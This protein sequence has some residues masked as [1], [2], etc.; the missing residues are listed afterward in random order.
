M[1]TSLDTTRPLDVL[2][3]KPKP[4]EPM[5]APGTAI[6][7]GYIVEGEKDSSL[8]GEQKYIT[9]SD[10]LANTA[11][12]AAGVRYFLNLVAKAGWKV[13]PADDSAEAQKYA[14]LVEDMLHDMDTPWHRVVR[15]A[16]MFKFYGFAI[17]EWTAKR[18]EDGIVG[19]QDIEP[20]AQ[21]TILRWDVDKHGKVL[22]V[23]QRNPQNGQDLY[24]PR[25]KLL[26]M[27]D[28]SLNDSPEGLG[29]FRHI[30]K[31]AKE[32]E[33]FELLESWG[34][35]TDLRGIPVARAP[36]AKLEQLVKEKKI[37]PQ[38]AQELRAPLEA[39]ID[40]HSKNPALGMLLD[41]S[42]YRAEGEMKSPSSTYLW[43][44][45]LLQG[46]GGPHAEVAAAI[47]RKN[48]E[49][50]RVLGVEQLLL[51]SD[52]KGSHALATDKTQSFGMI[53]DSTLVELREQT[54]KDV[55][56]PIWEL[57]GWP[58][59]MKPQLKTES[60]Q[61]RDIAQI[62]SALEGLAKA[63]APLAPNDPAINEVRQQA[64]LTDAPEQDMSVPTPTPAPEEPP[65]PEPELD[66]EDVEKAIRHRP[67][68]PGGGQFMPG[69]EGGGGI[70]GA[71]ASATGGEIQNNLHDAGYTTSVDIS[72]DDRFF[73]GASKHGRNFIVN[74][75]GGKAT[76]HA[77]SDRNYRGRV[78]KKPKDAASIANRLQ[79]VIDRQEAKHGVRGFPSRPSSRTP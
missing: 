15:R 16:A 22:G 76:M 10:M 38:Q 66:E 17:S 61:Y 29:L 47:E 31:K 77:L 68:G 40:K 45:E 44:A 79:V 30:A 25:A 56:G 21:L 23:I 53:V 28:D 11:I 36:L 24:L 73:M 2:E 51:G 35:E 52:S 57:N 6:F 39:F 62:V 67:A 19:L 1:V 20:R 59:E 3:E 37:S 48:R 46:D 54:R 69:S 4:F 65:A 5:G 72:R 60:I 13:E 70:G 41:S 75:E 12:V 74:V 43:S 14:D 58:K 32:L 7:G 26:Y 50:A 9:Y 49:I 64:G 55:L 78:I 27:C 34:F 63:G 33:K 8:T 71:S 18:R 42:V